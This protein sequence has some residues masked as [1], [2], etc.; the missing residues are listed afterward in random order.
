MLCREKAGFSREKTLFGT[1]KG[2]AEQ[3]EPDPER[4]VVSG[5]RQVTMT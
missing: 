2:S 3:K 5:L 4:A 1:E